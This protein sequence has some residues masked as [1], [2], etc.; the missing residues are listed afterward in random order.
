MGIKEDNLNKLKLFFN[1]KSTGNRKMSSVLSLSLCTLDGTYFYAEFNDFSKKHLSNYIKDKYISKMKYISSS[2]LNNFT[3]SMK[4]YPDR[5]KKTNNKEFMEDKKYNS[6]E[7]CGN[8]MDVSIELEKWLSQFKKK[9]NSIE[10]YGYNAVYQYVLLNDVLLKHYKDLSITSEQTILP[11][12][13][14]DII[15]DIS[16]ELNKSSDEILSIPLFK[17]TKEYLRKNNITER[18]N[19]LRVAIYS[20]GDVDNAL[21]D[22]LLISEFY[23]TLAEKKVD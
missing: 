23:K 3:V 7:M 1:V 18:N 20:N 4:L 12:I 17:V 19:P 16:N 8:I 21:H 2:K 11:S 15:F 6:I 14:K 5:R 10:L 9:K 13:Y 22:V